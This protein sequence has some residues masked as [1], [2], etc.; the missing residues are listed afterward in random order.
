MSYAELV[1][2]PNASDHRMRPVVRETQWWGQRP[3]ARTDLAKSYGPHLECLVTNGWSPSV[4]LYS[5]QEHDEY[6]RTGKHPGQADW[7]LADALVRRS[8]R[9][10]LGYLAIVLAFIGVVQLALAATTYSS[11]FGDPAAFAINTFGAALSLALA[12]LLWQLRRA[13][14]PM[15][16]IAA[17]AI[18]L[19][20]VR[21][22][23]GIVIGLLNGGTGALA[24]FLPV[25]ACGT[26]IY[27]IV[28]RVRELRPSS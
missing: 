9:A 17:A 6:A 20:A 18:A 7:P 2:L 12:A 23:L 10:R 21:A 16:G 1:Y 26:A 11:V 13:Q 8:A 28:Q 25:L 3:E 24:V 19:A 15:P 5:P 14:Q 4:S 27:L 22:L